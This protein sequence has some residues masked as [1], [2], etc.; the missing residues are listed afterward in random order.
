MRSLRSIARW[1]VLTP[2]LVAGSALALPWD[3]DMVDS[4]AHKGY[5]CWE[6]AKAK[7]GTPVCLNSMAH[8]P[9]FE[10]S[11]SQTN[12]LTPSAYATPLRDKLDP[13]WSQV[14][15][16]VPATQASLAEG[17][18]MFQIYCT[19]CHGKPDDQGTIAKLG[20]VAQP[21]RLS[22]V[23]ALTGPT[24]PLPNRTDG[25]VYRVIRL[26]NAIMPGYSWALTDHEM[27]SVVNYVRTLAGGAYQPPAPVAPEP[28]QQSEPALPEPAPTQ[29]N[30]P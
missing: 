16:P 25:D 20:T 3:V 29:E 10:G 26:G 4:Q 7:D 14:P 28:A 18:R 21:G 9:L 13:A 15:N 2:C 6:W 22:G 11:I 5:Q 30:Q 1:L 27:W 19:P 17:Q 24:S 12:P 23:V 8:R